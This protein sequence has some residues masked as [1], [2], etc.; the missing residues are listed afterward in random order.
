MPSSRP[1]RSDRAGEPTRWRVA[2]CV[3]LEVSRTSGRPDSSEAL[4]QWEYLFTSPPPFIKTH[5]DLLLVFTAAFTSCI[6]TDHL[7]IWFKHS[8]S[9]ES[10]PQLLGK[11]KKLFKHSL[12]GSC[13]Q[14]HYL[15]PDV[16]SAWLWSESIEPF[17]RPFCMFCHYVKPLIVLVSNIM[18]ITVIKIHCCGRF[19]S[20]VIQSTLKRSVLFESLRPWEF[21]PVPCKFAI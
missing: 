11:K 17:L 6:E 19:F 2:L 4:L 9:L 18:C 16:D 5:I 20:L 14:R 21:S 13:R 1:G 15:F 12:Q 10:F 7:E 8:K 3:H